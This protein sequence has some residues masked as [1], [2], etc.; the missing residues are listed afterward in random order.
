ME[1]EG[2]EGVVM[3]LVEGVGG[4]KMKESGCDQQLWNSTDNKIFPETNLSFD[5]RVCMCVNTAFSFPVFL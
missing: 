5:V 1:S 4:A 3:L 2:V